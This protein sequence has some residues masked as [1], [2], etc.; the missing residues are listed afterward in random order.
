[1]SI[2]TNSY[3]SIRR[4]IREATVTQASG[5][6]TMRCDALIELLEFLQKNLYI[7][8]FLFTVLNPSPNPLSFSTSTPF[9]FSS[10][11]F[12]FSL[13]YLNFP[14]FDLII[15]NDLQI[16]SYHYFLLQVLLILHF[17]AQVLL[18]EMC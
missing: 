17:I 3:S 16:N 14:K 5:S 4:C 8:F 15:I 1:M 2:L 13:S 9:A 12:K 18:Y 6:F 7:T 11:F 10:L